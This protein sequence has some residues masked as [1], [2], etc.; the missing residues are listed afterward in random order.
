MQF[1]GV[2][3]MGEKEKLS[4][5]KFFGGGNFGGNFFLFFENIFGDHFYISQFVPS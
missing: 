3:I 4:N 1:V 5:K 2:K